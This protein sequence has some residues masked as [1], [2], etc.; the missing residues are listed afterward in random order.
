MCAHLQAAPRS[1][2]FKGNVEE[3]SLS[4]SPADR[5][6]VGRLSAVDLLLLVYNRLCV[7]LFRLYYFYNH[8]TM[9]AATYFFICI[10][11][12]LALFEEPA[13]F[14]LPFLVSIRNKTAN[15]TLP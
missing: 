5:L 15:W 11:L 2:E 1:L 13:L 7:F 6:L 4:I 8:W 10:D 3:P 9:Q 14:P 12:S